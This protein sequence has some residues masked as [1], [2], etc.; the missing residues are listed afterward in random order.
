MKDLLL[1]I[2]FILT[3]VAYLIAIIFSILKVIFDFFVGIITDKKYK[4]KLA[5]E[6]ELEKNNEMKRN[7][8]LT[9][10]S[11]LTRSEKMSIFESLID[12]YSRISNWKISEEKS[13]DFLLLFESMELKDREKIVQDIQLIVSRREYENS[14]DSLKNN[15]YFY[16]EPYLKQL[17]AKLIKMESLLRK[18]D[19]IKPN[20]STLDGYEF[21]QYCAE[22]LREEGYIDV[23]VSKGSGDRGVDITAYKSGLL[24]VFQCKLYSDKVPRKAIQEIYTGM[25]IYKADYG[26]IMTN[27]TLTP[28]AQ[29]DANELR[30]EVMTIS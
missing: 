3:A 27:S 13:K 9:K 24:Y 17:L 28:G 21:E 11:V 2:N 30:I 1:I 16:D 20:L 23:V 8:R 19:K 4:K 14:I 12:E 15:K 29:M 18:R 6:N 7:D 22:I 25:Q 10:F 26:V 5:L